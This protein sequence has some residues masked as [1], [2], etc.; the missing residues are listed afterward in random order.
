MCAFE[1]AWNENITSPW[2]G[3]LSAYEFEI[4]EFADD[5]R[6]YW[7]D[8]YKYQLTHKQACPAI[9]DMFDFFRYVFH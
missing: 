6:Y 1:T 3:L 9:I 4:L 8:G 2:C 7:I 5:L